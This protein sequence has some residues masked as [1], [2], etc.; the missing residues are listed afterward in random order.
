VSIARARRIV[1]DWKPQ[2]YFS[3]QSVRDFDVPYVLGSFFNRYIS[4]PEKLEEKALQAKAARKFLD[5]N[6]DGASIDD[7]VLE[8]PM[9]EPLITKMRYHIGVFFDEP[10]VMTDLY[11]LVGH[12]PNRTTD[13]AFVDAFLHNKEQAFAGTKAALQQLLCYL[14]WDVPLHDQLVSKDDDTRS[15]IN[16]MDLGNSKGWRKN[17]LVQ[18]VRYTET[19][20]V[21]KKFDS[22]RTM[23]PEP[24]T[25]AFFAKAV[26]RWITRKLLTKC[27]IDLATQPSVHKNMARLA[28]LYD[29]VKVATVDWS[30]ASDRIWLTLVKAV[31][32]EGNAPSWFNFMNHVCRVGRTC[33]KWD[34]TFGATSDFADEHVLRVYL[35][36]RT[37]EFTITQSAGNYSVIAFVDTT[38]IATMGNPLTFPLQTLVFWAF[39]TAC[40]E[41]AAD[42]L[43]IPL[44]EMFDP[45]SFGD[46]G[47]VDSRAR[48]EILRYAPLLEWRL[49]VDKSF[50]EGSFKESCGGDYYSGRYCRP[51]EPKRP[52]L[53]KLLTNSQNR[54]RYQAWLYICYNNV[55]NLV[56]ELGGDPICVDQWLAS[57]MKKAKLGLIHIVPPSY[58]DGSGARISSET[59]LHG[60]I[61]SDDAYSS[62]LSYV[63]KTC[64]MDTHRSDGPSE[65]LTHFQEYHK[66]EW[67]ISTGFRFRALLTTPGRLTL[68]EEDEFYYYHNALQN[69]NRGQVA[70][71]KPVLDYFNN[72][73]K[74]QGSVD[75][76][77][78]VPL[79][80]CIIYNRQTSCHNWQ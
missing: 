8:H 68:N 62:W 65:L 3:G 41:L 75:C 74:G 2:K 38:M 55:C 80:E 5:T 72:D 37:D 61:Y 64:H 73:V 54:K 78:T 40:T 14:H 48:E 66:I 56:K 36:E 16:S 20:F 26:A 21:P 52:P 57:E 59:E 44:V 13:I 23:C 25:V 60:Y 39:L 9:L 15:L 42:R 27:N 67:E 6:F 50:F 77:G 10:V 33:V 1:Q 47:L 31:M 24:T 19:S 70:E 4:V 63:L 29:D 58:P 51:F 18:V 43:D 30:E 11:E 17:L 69:V 49:N 32:S 12:G 71:Y 45:S 53:D 76:E 34:G 7:Y 35:E 22:L 28:S 79:K 46:D